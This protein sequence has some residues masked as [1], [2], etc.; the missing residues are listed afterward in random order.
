MRGRSSDR[1]RHLLLAAALFG[2]VTVGGVPLAAAEPVADIAATGITGAIVP[3]P[4]GQPVLDTTAYFETSPAC[5][6]TLEGSW[7]LPFQTYVQSSTDGGMTFN[8]GALVSTVT[9]DNCGQLAGGLTAQTPVTGA[10][11]SFFAAHPAA[12]ESLWFSSY[13]DSRRFSEPVSWNNSSYSALPQA[14]VRDLDLN[15]TEAYI[16]DGGFALN[17][18]GRLHAYA[19][20]AADPA[21]DGSAADPAPAPV[22]FYL[23]A[24][25][26]AATD[27]FDLGVQTLTTC[28]QVNAGLSVD[29]PIAGELAAFAKAHP[30]DTYSWDVYTL[31][32][33]SREV[34]P[35]LGNNWDIVPVTG[36][37]HPIS[38]RLWFGAEGTGF[39]TQ[40]AYFDVDSTV[41]CPGGAFGVSSSAV[42][43][44][45][46]S[47]ST[48]AFAGDDITGYTYC[49]REGS[50]TPTGPDLVYVYGVVEGRATGPLLETPDARWRIGLDNTGL[51]VLEA[52]GALP[53]GVTIHRI[54]KQTATL[55]DGSTR[56]VV[57]PVPRGDN[58]LNI[59]YTPAGPTFTATPTW[60][61]GAVMVR[62]KGGAFIRAAGVPVGFHLSQMQLLTVEGVARGEFDDL[63]YL[64]DRA[65]SHLD[66]RAT[67]LGP[68][69]DIRFETI[70]PTGADAFQ[71]RPDGLA[72][73]FRVVDAVQP[74]RTAF[75]EVTMTWAAHR[76]SVRANRLRANFLNDGTGVGPETAELT[77]GTACKTCTGGG[78]D[79]KY[80]TTFS[81][82]AQGADGTV[83]ARARNLADPAFGPLGSDGGDPEPAFRRDGD[84]PRMAWLTLPGFTFGDTGADGAVSLPA[85]LL[86]LVGLDG[87]GMPGA[88][89]PLGA[90]STRLGNGYGA[91]L[92]LGPATYSDAA[93]QPVPTDADED[94]SGTR[95]RIGFVTGAGRTY[96][97]L[98]STVGT[99]YIVRR[100]GLTGVFNFSGLPVPQPQISGFPTVFDDEGGRR[101]FA[102]RMWSNTLDRES[103]IKARL[104]VQGPAGFDV[105]LA[106]MGLECT[107]QVT[108]G[109][110]VADATPQDLDAWKSPY[111]IHTAE[112]SVATG[113]DLCGEDPRVLRVGGTVY[114]AAL[115]KPLELTADWSP[116][117]VA[118]SVAVTGST[119]NELDRASPAEA[120]FPVQLEKDVSIGL[121]GGDGY[122]ALSGRV[123]VPF[124]D[125]ISSVIRL[126]NRPMVAGKVVA[127]T[128]LVAAASAATPFEGTQNNDWNATNTDQIAKRRLDVHYDWLAGISF[129]L[130]VDYNSRAVGD[131][132]AR[133]LGQP[134]ED[135][136][137]GFMTVKR[138]VDFVSPKHTKVSFGASGDVSKIRLSKVALNVDLNDPKSIAKV[139]G[140][141]NSLGIGG[142]PVYSIVHTVKEPGDL[143]LRYVG[144]GLRDLLHEGIA[145]VLKPVEDGLRT[146]ADAMN[147]V[148]SVPGQVSAALF[149]LA[150]DKVGDIAAALSGPA[151]VAA[152]DLY[153]TAAMRIADLIVLVNSAPRN[154]DNTYSLALDGPTRADLHALVGKIATLHGVIK[155]AK[156]ALDS[157]VSALAGASDTVAAVYGNAKAGI[158]TAQKALGKTKGVLS[159]VNTALGSGSNAIFDKLTSLTGNLTDFVNAL[160]SKLLKG[161]VSNLGGV[162]GLDTILLTAAQDSIAAAGKALS[163][164]VNTA[165]TKLKTEWGKL[166][167]KLGTATKSAQTMVDDVSTALG[168]F[169]GKLDGLLKPDPS[170]KPALLLTVNKFVVD[171]IAPL[172]KSLGT[173]DTKLANL[174][175]A[176]NAAIDSSVAV[177][178]PALDSD[179]AKLVDEK[180][181]RLFLADAVKD[182]LGL[183]ATPTLCTSPGNGPVALVASAIRDK[184]DTGMG[185]VAADVNAALSDVLA[186]LPFPTADSLIA[187]F[188]KEVF[189]ADAIGQLDT[190]VNDNLTLVAKNVNDL[191][192]QFFNHINTVVKA[193]ADKLN[194]LVS[195]LLSS[196]QAAFDA[197][198][199]R[200]GKVDGYA[201][202][203]ANELERVHVEA[204][205][206]LGRGG[207][208]GSADADNKDSRTTFSAALDVTSWGANGKAKNCLC[209]GGACTGGE[210]PRTGIVDASITARDLPI[211]IGTGDLR[212]SLL[213][214]G[215]TLES[216]SVKGVFGSIQTVGVLAFGA[217]K[218]MNLGL[219]A[220]VGEWE[221][222][223]GASGA[224]SFEGVDLSAVFM[225][226]KACNGDALRQL[227]PEVGKFLTLPGDMFQGA[228]ARGSASIPIITG[229]CG[230]TVGAGADIGF[231]LLT[232]AGITNVGGL[233]GG[234]VFGEALCLVGLRGGV[235][236]LAESFDGTFRFRGKGYGVGGF[237]F[238]CDP[239][240][241]TSIDRSRDD[242]W[243]ATGDASITAEYTDGF[244]IG[245]PDV[246]GLF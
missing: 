148:Q 86:G 161:L 113:G 207:S 58:M 182:V 187:T 60:D 210:T 209:S 95:M 81:D 10:L 145:A 198:P 168:K 214:L 75:P 150:K 65:F 219:A 236:M 54:K 137:L 2:A 142:T 16:V 152:C 165:V 228:Y 215:M 213:Q 1:N 56:T 52:E 115:T 204:Q 117:G 73:N 71:I 70:K 217:L 51:T 121:A 3:G 96:S 109:T 169:E 143:V 42:L 41:A 62:A 26:G 84:A 212:L 160:S 175:A 216:A 122:F 239:E 154:P 125:A 22:H 176:L 97:S 12:G 245:S 127:Q 87:E 108:G 231:W 32:D 138:G 146:L 141:L 36:M 237:G 162:L 192:Q 178:V 180:A 190:L 34:A 203:N 90:T 164:Q 244:H 229:G 225:A 9:V 50:M 46:P 235:Q 17:G 227:D 191:G 4:D 226:G 223:I 18:A 233:M 172:Q 33:D 72:V 243:C 147:F 11:Q 29:V 220:G 139:D 222:Y 181:V 79:I 111:D 133:F 200:G 38:G 197:L 130:P 15:Y 98:T 103:W 134:L 193:A 5:S 44:W 7:G 241:W 20:F 149:G 174:E 31:L 196:A 57:R 199:I 21:C 30:K 186:S 183:A 64:R 171:N 53:E 224:A 221:N 61:L 68:S 194:A 158:G 120:G 116:A 238:D 184:V 211:S 35:N 173:F 188:R 100:G 206:T 246:N 55:P 43:T 170:G 19:G 74:G 140:F 136:A 205:F 89:L 201:L 37:Y 6:D 93:A 177:P 67:T 242:S 101:P 179:L 218:L 234:S 28:A 185:T 99:K 94:L 155:R 27:V 88:I 195:G 82:S 13:V 114:P 166:S 129:T 119:A 39:A 66:P 69:N 118:T 232:G 14:P 24:T 202:I 49:V 8:A 83:M 163:T 107:G 240:T 92:T 156:D 157:V 85:R 151:D 104:S 77:L 91:G 40:Y 102:F 23:E 230:L 105:E 126:Q 167:S 144:P 112:M 123:L 63:V 25:L 45:D 106:S 124:W 78:K 76:V 48:H 128:S 189:N 110:L 153:N 159:D 131:D 47:R 80:A 208:S 132:A 59:G 135:N